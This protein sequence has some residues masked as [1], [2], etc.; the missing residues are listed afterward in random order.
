MKIWTFCTSKRKNRVSACKQLHFI[1]ASC[2]PIYKHLN[3]GQFYKY[4]KIKNEINNI[5]NKKL[6]K[7]YELD[8]EW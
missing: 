4:K 6:K 8:S 5:L 7:D 3:V 2:I 1:L